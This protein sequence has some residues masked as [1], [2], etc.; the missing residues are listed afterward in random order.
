MF[1]LYHYY[2][3]E[4]PPKLSSWPG[5]TG[6]LPHERSATENFKHGG[7]TLCVSFMQGLSIYYAWNYC[8]P[9]S[10]ALSRPWPML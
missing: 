6:S 8:N 1:L 2:R 9:E 10:T 5:I 4:G 3:V 7:L